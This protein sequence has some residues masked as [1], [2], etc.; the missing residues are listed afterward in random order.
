MS[1]VYMQLCRVFE[2]T[3]AVGQLGKHMADN[4]GDLLWV[5]RCTQIC[6]SIP[7]PI[8]DQTGTPKMP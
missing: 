2:S 8:P 5:T 1:Y 3:R 6:P 4:K 7:P